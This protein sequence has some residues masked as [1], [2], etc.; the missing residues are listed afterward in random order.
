MAVVDSAP[1]PPME[2]AGFDGRAYAIALASKRLLERAGIWERLPS[3]PC[4]IEG[5]KV[6]DGRVGEAPS[7]LDLD[8]E[9]AEVARTAAAAEASASASARGRAARGAIQKPAS[10]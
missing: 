9:A 6:A 3:A 10:E 7:S 8:F 1:L 2:L 4:P 5:I